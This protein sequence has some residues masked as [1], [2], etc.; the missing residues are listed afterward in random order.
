MD[1]TVRVWSV[2]TGQCPHTLIGHTSL[3]GLLGLSSCHIVSAAADSTLR[4]WDSATAALQHTLSGQTGAIT[5]FQHDEF[6]VA[7]GSDGELK[8][9][10]VRTGLFIRD[11]LTDLTAVWQVVF[12]GQWCVAVINRQDATFLEVW[13]FG[14]D[15]NKNVLELE[16]EEWLEES[17]EEDDIIDRKA[18]TSG[19]DD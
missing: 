9:W 12:E 1:E 5:C 14:G 16:Q 15:R 8:L 18:L 7:S 6:K 2:A 17:D 10:D 19:G 3:V 13:Y 4:V 11:L